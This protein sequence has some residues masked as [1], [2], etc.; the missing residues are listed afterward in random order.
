MPCTCSGAVRNVGG[1][2]LASRT[3]NRPLVPAPTP[4]QEVKLKE[5]RGK[6]AAAQKHFAEMEPRMAAAQAKWEKSLKADAVWTSRELLGAELLATPA[7][8]DGTKAMDAGNFA[9]YG[10]QDRFSLAFRLTTATGNGVI[11][12]RMADDEANPAGYGL[13]LENGKV[14]VQFAVR[15]LDDAMLLESKRALEKNRSYHLTVTYDGSRYATGVKLYVDGEEWELDAPLDALNQDF[16]RPGPL[17]FGGGGGWEHKFTGEIGG[18]RAYSRVLRPVDVAMLATADPLGTV[19][20]VPAARACE[21]LPWAAAS[22]AFWMFWRTWSSCWRT[23]C[24]SMASA[25]LPWFFW[26]TSQASGWACCT[27]VIRSGVYRASSRL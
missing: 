16:R 21:G 24:N 3:P 23:R 17:V 13:N 1:H 15:R 27:Q 11:L 20:R 19:A 26:S 6:L 14:Q 18:F 7:K 12:H 25:L 10:F 9:E 8:F 22:A 2:S 5:L 4:D